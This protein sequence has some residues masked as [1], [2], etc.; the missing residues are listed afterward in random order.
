MDRIDLDALRARREAAADPDAHHTL[1][2]GGVEFP[3]PAKPPYAF[4]R[5]VSL[6]NP[7]RPDEMI[8]MVDTGLRAVFGV[9]Y[10]ELLA[11]GLEED[12]MLDIVAELTVI[13]Y[14]VTVGESAASR[15][16]SPNGGVRSRPTSDA[17]TSSTS[18]TSGA[19]TPPTSDVS[20]H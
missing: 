2:A 18:P 16:P 13:Y 17:T 8:A 9:R 12:D 19:P 6:A 3:F 4:S 11:L 1:T 14:G 15:E 7:A 10:D 5:A 20:P